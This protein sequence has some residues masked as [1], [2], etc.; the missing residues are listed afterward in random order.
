M[1]HEEHV[2]LHTQ[3][4]VGALTLARVTLTPGIKTSTRHVKR[5]AQIV[6][7][8]RVFHGFDQGETLPFGPAKIPTAFFKMS[9]WLVTL[10]S[11][12]RNRRTSACNS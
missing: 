12:A 3:D 8:I 9:R 11:C 10:W 2:D 7:R 1:S 4:G 6:D 5:L